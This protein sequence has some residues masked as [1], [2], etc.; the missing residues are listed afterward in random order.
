MF[1][2]SILSIIEEAK[3][4]FLLLFDCCH[5]YHPPSRPSGS[6]RNIIEVISAVGFG[7]IAAEPGADSFTH[8]LDEALA[9][10]KRNG[11]IKAVDLYMDI[12]RRL[13]PQ[14]PRRLRRDR[15]F[16]VDQNGPVEQKSPRRCPLHYWLSGQPKTITLAPFEPHAPAFP[17]RGVPSDEPSEVLRKAS[18]TT[19]AETPRDLVGTGIIQIQRAEFPQ[20]LVCFRVTRDDFDPTEWVKWL[21]EAPPEARDLV[22]I[23]GFYG[24]F[25]SLLLVRMPVQVWSLLPGSPSVS[26]V[27]FVTTRN[28]GPRLQEEVD[29]LFS[30][31]HEQSARS[32][33]TTKPSD[34]IKALGQSKGHLVKSDRDNTPSIPSSDFN[35]LTV[36]ETN[37]PLEPGHSQFPSENPW[38]NI[39]TFRRAGLPLFVPNNRNA[40]PELKHALILPSVTGSNNSR[41][42]R[43]SKRLAVEGHS[44][45]DEDGFGISSD[46][47][48]TKSARIDEDQY[49]SCPY[50]KRNPVRFNV[51][52]HQ[53]CAVQ[54][55]PDIAQLK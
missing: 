4:D 48:S 38:T 16:V 18:S 36:G 43:S 11:P 2:G 31:K 37:F 50:R 52:D 39:V 13:F 46:L 24:S 15:S 14:T 51:R 29:S 49:L 30:A 27:G 40:S 32:E 25:S 34:D 26:F 19:A 54:S 5:A 45:E 23:D 10:A 44:S 28:E 21:L 35:R 3:S 53:N 22:R 7:T 42:I 8:H 12:M 20:V 9:L 55:F 41:S 17:E 33:N 6:G 47:G 1:S